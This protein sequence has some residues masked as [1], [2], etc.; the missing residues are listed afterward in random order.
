MVDA[1]SGPDPDEGSGWLPGSP[2]CGGGG[3][4]VRN[5]GGATRTASRGLMG[6]GELGS[7]VGTDLAEA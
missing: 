6:A 2:R 1:A 7:T 4:S 5:E 3:L